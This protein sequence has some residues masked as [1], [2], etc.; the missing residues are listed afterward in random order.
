M[1]E[2]RRASAKVEAAGA[3]VTHLAVLADATEPDRKRARRVLAAIEAVGVP[4]RLRFFAGGLFLDRT[5]VPLDSRRFR[6]SERVRAALGASGGQELTFESAPTVDQVLALGDALARGSNNRETRETLRRSTIRWRALVS[7]P[8]I[9]AS[10]GS[11][12]SAALSDASTGDYALR[13]ADLVRAAGAVRKAARAER[14]TWPWTLSIAVLRRLEREAAEDRFALVRGIELLPGPWTIP[15]RAVAA[16]AAAWTVLE[17]VAVSRSTIRAVAHAVLA[18]GVIGYQER[19]ARALDRVAKR[20]MRRMTAP[21]PARADDAPH[22]PRV[23]ALTL[24]L[25]ARGRGGGGLDVAPLV[26]TVYRLEAARCPTR[27]G[28]PLTRGALMALAAEGLGRDRGAGWTRL[29]IEQAGPLPPGAWVRLPDDRVGVVVDPGSEA[30]RRP[31]IL[32]EDEIVRPDTGVV[33][34]AT[35]GSLRAATG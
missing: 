13:V 9:A 12:E 32:V 16:C 2:V 5:L 23:I 30:A 27:G 20:L 3:L 28:E 31:R 24:D 22:R 18:L 35:T 10:P 11:S 6:R 19:G 26:E 1:T 25:V 4:C 7:R 21:R 8:A 29:L 33:L 34:T 17:A 15:R 14:G